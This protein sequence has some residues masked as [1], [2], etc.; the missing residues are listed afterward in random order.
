MGTNWV[1]SYFPRGNCADA[2][3]PA[4]EIE[5]DVVHEL[6]VPFVFPEVTA[7]LGAACPAPWTACDG[8]AFGG[9]KLTKSTPVKFY[10]DRLPLPIIP[11]VKSW[12]EALQELSS[13]ASSARGNRASAEFR[14]LSRM[15]GI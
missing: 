3:E 10:G 8:C 2:D 1:N 7:C 5:C 6:H 4:D 12:H 9:A 14:A 11:E 13:A 15:M